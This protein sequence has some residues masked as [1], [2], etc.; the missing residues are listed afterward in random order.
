MAPAPQLGSVSLKE[1]SRPVFK[2][3]MLAIAL[4]GAFVAT[5]CDL[6]HVQ[7]GTLVYPAPVF[8]GQAWWPFLAFSL[9]FLWMAFLYRLLDRFLPA[10]VARAHATSAGTTAELAESLLLFAFVYLLSG[11]G[12]ASPLFLS[13]VFYAA[14]A[15]RFA[16]A[17]ERLFLA[18]VSVNLAVGG[19]L[20][21]GLMSALG[22]VAYT[23]YDFLLVPAWL[24]GLYLH[25][26]FALRDGYRRFVAEAV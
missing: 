5:F 23:R 21:E 7:T 8:M 25:G 2:P 20:S 24:P 19:T 14:F 26:A 15:I 4:L 17:R 16:L 1:S 3:G 10:S 9:A 18:I 12:N 6:M 13:A 22:L 11:F